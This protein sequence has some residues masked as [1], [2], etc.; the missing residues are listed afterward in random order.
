M[1]NIRERLIFA[2][3]SSTFVYLFLV[4]LEPFELN[5]H[6]VENHQWI[7]LGYGLITFLMLSI[8]Y[9]LLPLFIPSLITEE[10]WKAYKE[11]VW[12]AVN[13]FLIGFTLAV[14]EHLIPI[15]PLSWVSIYETIGKTIVIG[16][17]SVIGIVVF[18][19]IRL[20]K[21]HIGEANQINTQIGRNAGEEIEGDADIISLESE[22]K[23]E[24]FQKRVQSIMFLAAWGNYVEI[25]TEEN[26]EVQKTILRTTLSKAEK[27]LSKYSQ[28]YRCHRAYMVNIQSITS[29]DGNASGYN[30][31]F[32]NTDQTVPVARRNTAKF[33]MIINRQ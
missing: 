2:L 12:L 28:L 11:I 14:Y 5:L 26:G 7:V 31:H 29:I 19:Y 21:K 25:H 9:V 3:V 23:S 1:L 6:P 20:L 30:L 4:I 22:N 24:S 17:F 16:S 18:N 13:L 27:Q 32:N 10:K 8:F 15:R 33:N